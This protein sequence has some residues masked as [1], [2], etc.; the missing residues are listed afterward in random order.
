MKAS[1]ILPNPKVCLCIDYKENKA[2]S[3]CLVVVQSLYFPF[4]G[5]DHNSKDTDL[6]MFI[7]ICNFL[8]KVHQANQVNLTLKLQK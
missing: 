3:P 4:F 1:F 6:S 8:P 7:L 5:P 2:A